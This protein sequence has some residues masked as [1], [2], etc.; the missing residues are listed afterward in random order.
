MTVA[1][2]RLRLAPVVIAIVIAGAALASTTPRVGVPLIV[3]RIEVS[4]IEVHG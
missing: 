3:S 1:R 4:R 2:A